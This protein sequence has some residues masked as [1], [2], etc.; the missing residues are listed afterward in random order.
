MG[1]DP[2]FI[3]SLLSSAD[4]SSIFNSLG[5]PIGVADSSFKIKWVSEELKK[6]V[7]AD[8]LEENF[9]K[10]FGIPKNKIN[11]QSCFV[12]E[13]LFYD[14]S[15]HSDQVEK[16][17]YYF[18]F[19][20]RKVNVSDKITGRLKNI[21]TYTHD[22]N[23]I[24]TSVLNTVSAIKQKSG[25]SGEVNTHLNNLE[26][27]SKRASEIIDRMMQGDEHSPAVKKRV[28]IKV[29]L[30]DVYNSIQSLV[31]K[32]IEI[33][34][35]IANNIKDI[36]GSY[37]DLYRVFL[38]L[39]VNASEAIGKTGRIVI[40]AE[41]FVKHN[42][43]DLIRSATEEY[44]KISVSDTGSG[45]KKRHIKRIFESNFSTKKRNR[46]SGFGL[47]I[48]KEIVADHKGKI[49]IQTKWRKGT[50]FNVFFP[51]RPEFEI[52]ASNVGF[53]YKIIVADDE[54]IILDLLYELLES[55]NYD[56]TKAINGNEVL[57]ATKRK[58]S[59]D[60]YIIDRKMPEL[61]G[62]ECVKKLR[63]QGVNAPIILTTGSQ[64]FKEENELND[65]MI[66]EIM[67]KPYDFKEVLEKVNE[68]IP[69]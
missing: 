15:I 48:V 54:E 23:N 28:D 25:Y 52:P 56:V 4:L 32:E 6:I 63:E 37:S 49:D 33:D 19:I 44:I 16:E 46:E 18:F 12:H 39:C 2:Q 51:V 38:N 67:V 34:F 43:P 17:K 3:N 66:Q 40:T 27:S 1:T 65:L 53:K 26:S 59:F 50:T 62:V 47:N 5:I 41:N 69:A 61:D 14:V 7:D 31:R 20:I 42:E 68:L 45:I 58:N 35:H 64:S 11:S 55:Y 29:L 10:A 24:L 30:N 60:L 13:T 9:I 8:L 22:L 21:K 57:K 36:T